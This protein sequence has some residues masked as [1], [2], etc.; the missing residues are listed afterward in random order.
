[1]S[2]MMYVYNNITNI[3][4]VVPGT[5]TT[6]TFFS[7]GDM[8]RS[9]CTIHNKSLVVISKLHVFTL[10]VQI[11]DPRLCNRALRLG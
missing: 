3:T 11:I 7:T 9:R 2:C 1:M 10:D 6:S 4:V 8:V 5:I